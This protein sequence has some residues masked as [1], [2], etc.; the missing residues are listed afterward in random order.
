MGEKKGRER[1]SQKK[2][3][4]SVSTKFLGTCETVISKGRIRSRYVIRGVLNDIFT[5]SVGYIGVDFIDS[6]VS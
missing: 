1:R 3:K 6:C 4:R 2:R 5:L